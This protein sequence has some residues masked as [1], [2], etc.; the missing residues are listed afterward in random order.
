MDVPVQPGV[1]HED[2]QATAD[3]EHH[4]KEIDVMRDTG[5]ADIAEAV[6]NTGPAATSP[7]RFSF[8]IRPTR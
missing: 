1:G 4:E 6:K 3:D 5:K 8:E 2:L 7:P